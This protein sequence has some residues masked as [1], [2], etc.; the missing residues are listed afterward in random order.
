MSDQTGITFARLHGN[1]HD[2][3]RVNIA[4]SLSLNGLR[5]NSIIGRRYEQALHKTIHLLD[6]DRA[7]EAIIGRTYKPNKYDT[8]RTINNHLDNVRT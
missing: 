4:R 6:A 2:A 7:K 3:A 8:S 5:K 1:D